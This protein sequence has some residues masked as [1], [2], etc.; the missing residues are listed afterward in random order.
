MFVD[1]VYW[2]TQDYSL[3]LLCLL[4]LF[5]WNC[6]IFEPLFDMNT[7]I[8][9]SGL[10]KSKN[11]ANLVNERAQLWNAT[12][13]L[14]LVL[15]WTHTNSTYCSL[16]LLFGIRQSTCL[17][18]LWFGKRVLLRGLKDCP[19]VKIE[20][21]LNKQVMEFQHAISSKYPRLKDVWGAMD[22]LKV[23]ILAAEDDVTQNCFCNG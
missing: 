23:N 15:V 3:I 6:S 4:A 9:Q 12:S 19:H 18:W 13:C 7:P 8:S 21:P 1:C 2:S 11:I 16:C 14:G 5:S 22:S 20:M 17:E 10:I